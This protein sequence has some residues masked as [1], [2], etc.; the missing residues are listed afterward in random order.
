MHAIVWLWHGVWP[1]LEASCSNHSWARCSPQPRPAN[2]RTLRTRALPVCS[3]S[4]L[5]RFLPKMKP[6][7]GASGDDADCWRG[8]AELPLECNDGDGSDDGS[9]C[10]AGSEA[11]LAILVPGRQ[12]DRRGSLAWF[13]AYGERIDMRLL[14][15]S[16]DWK[17]LLFRMASTRSR[18]WT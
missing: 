7:S 5:S 12:M 8:D 17:M 9:L 16:S 11:I 1:S 3:A 15:R 18:S 6:A 10:S 13:V 14:L 2:A 4:L